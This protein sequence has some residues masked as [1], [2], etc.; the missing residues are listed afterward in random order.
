[1][2]V[3]GREPGF[4]G[5][6]GVPSGAGPGPLCLGIDE[7]MERRKG[8]RIAAKGVYRVGVRSSLGYFVKA[9]GLRWV[10]LMWLVELPW[11]QRVWALPFLS[12]L[13]PSNRYHAARHRRHQT[14]TDWARQML[15][16]VRRWLPDHE[17]GMVGDRGGR[18]ARA[19]VWT[20]LRQTGPDGTVLHLQYVSDTSLWYRT[21]QPSVPLPWLLVREPEQCLEPQPCSAPTLPSRRPSS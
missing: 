7:T 16:C 2:V 5:P 10:S 12:A 1:M 15:C 11:V 9:M 3:S 17:P 13:A 14:V 18:G 19:T 21:G 8:P 4:A 20:P 6:A